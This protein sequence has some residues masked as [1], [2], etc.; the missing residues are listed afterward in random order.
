MNKEDGGW[1]FTKNNND[2]GKYNIPLTSDGN[3]V[4][5]GD[6]ASN[7]DDMRWTVA[8]IETFLLY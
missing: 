5:T 2:D 7:P 8:E 1:C 3:S 6:G 4:L